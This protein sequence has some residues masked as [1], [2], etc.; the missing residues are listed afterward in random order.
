MGKQQTIS[1][2]TDDTFASSLRYISR[3]LAEFDPE[4]IKK[5]GRNFLNINIAYDI[6]VNKMLKTIVDGIADVVV[7]DYKS[8]YIES[9][10]K[11]SIEDP[12]SRHAFIRAL[13]NFDRETDKHIAKKLIKITPNF[14]LDS[15]FQFMINDLK[16]RWNEVIDLANENAPFLVCEGTFCE[17]L[18]FLISNL[19]SRSDVVHIYQRTD[20]IEVLSSTSKPFNN[21]YINDDLPADVHAICKL[22][23]IAP[24][25]IY[26]HSSG[27]V[28]VFG[29]IQNIFGSRVVSVEG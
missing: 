2:S 15:F 6:D 17:L 1:I 5:S 16:T 22:I 26:L 8:H 27:D 3:R 29:F 13:S 20:G 14:L 10:L 9:N 21:I 23:S 18:R 28:P 11:V 12:I 4:I 7:T 25:K 24:K 19:E